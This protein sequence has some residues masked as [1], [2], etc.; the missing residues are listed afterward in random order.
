MLPFSECGMS[1]KTKQ[2]KVYQS[3]AISF[4][5]MY[6]GCFFP[7]HIV[8]FLRGFLS[9]A[10]LF[11]LSRWGALSLPSTFPQKKPQGT[12]SSAYL[13]QGWQILSHK[14]HLPLFIIFYIV[15]EWET[16][17]QCNSMYTYQGCI[18][19]VNQTNLSFKRF[20]T[21]VFRVLNVFAMWDFSRN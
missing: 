19:D 6:G 21:T 12:M 17:N 20:C 11:F 18:V 8:C 16:G 1:L 3:Q 10:P 2:N 15:N 7:P 14:L 4:E 13:V 9:P 5:E